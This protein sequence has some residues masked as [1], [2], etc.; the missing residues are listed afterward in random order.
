MNR[1]LSIACLQYSSTKDEILTLKN[2]KPFINQAIERG[3]EL[4]VLPECATTLQ[5]N[6]LITKESAKPESENLS[7]QTFIEIAKSN[8]VYF[9]VGSLPIKISDKL[10]NRSFLIGPNGDI[11]YKYDKI[12][13]YDVTLPNG[14]IYQ[15]S[16]TY[17]AGSKAIIATIY[18]SIRIGM[19]ICYDVRFPY[20]Y[21][22]LAQNG[23]E[24]IVVPSAFSNVTG[25]VH[26][27]TLLKARAIET[28]CYIV[29]AAQTG[30]HQCGRKTYG[31]SLIVSPWGEIMK[32]ANKKVGLINC[33]INLDEVQ[34][35]RLAIPSLNS[36][37]I[38]STNF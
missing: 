13:L 21:W 24:I 35:A 31:H 29:A 12:H 16:N 34:K 27:H 26:W 22:D 15:E 23:A 4:I 33:Q 37:Q 2:I 25:P 30:H 32:D 36:K 1:Y 19:T 10:A 28:G 8:A 11:L 20:L 18:N 5:E 17:T 38:Y 9:L 3:A 6:A 14:D 7:L